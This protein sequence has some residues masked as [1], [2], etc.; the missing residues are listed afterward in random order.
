MQDIASWLLWL[1]NWSLFNYG[2]IGH[3]AQDYPEAPIT[4]VNQA[5]Q[6]TNANKNWVKQGVSSRGGKRQERLDHK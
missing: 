2:Q 3:L 6:N 5:P 1:R 4:L